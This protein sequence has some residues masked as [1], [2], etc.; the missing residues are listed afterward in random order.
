MEDIAALCQ[1]VALLDDGRIVATG[2][3]REIFSQ[4]ELLHAHHLE[5]PPV[6]RVAHTLRAQGWDISNDILFADEL[7][8]ALE[9]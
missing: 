2:T 8:A 3:H 1:K 6:A 4:P 9:N 7:V 5:L